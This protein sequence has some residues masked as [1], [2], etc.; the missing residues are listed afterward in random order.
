MTFFAKEILGDIEVKVR[1]LSMDDLPLIEA[2]QSKVYAALPDQT[3]LQ[4]LSTEEYEYI[5]NDQGIMIGVFDKEKLIG[6][7]AL[8]DPPVDEEHLGYDCGIPEEQFSRVLY[9]EISNVSPDY[10][11]YNL[12]KKMAKW[13]MNEID[14]GRYDY[15]CSTVQPYNIPS[16]K[17]KLSQGLIVKALKIKYIDKLRYVFFKN[18]KQ[19]PIEYREQQK[20]VMS[21]VEAQQ[22]ILKDGFVG[23]QMIEQE[24]DWYMVYEK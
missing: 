9:Q 1:H 23:T 18:L 22:R 17:D 15:V 4:P 7:R 11:G 20:I 3:V 2:L 10:R 6:F 5:L 19:Q 24:N 12:Q 21:D 16:L 14:L 8:L 13:S